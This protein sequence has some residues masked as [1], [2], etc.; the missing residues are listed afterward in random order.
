MKNTPGNPEIKAGQTSRGDKIDGDIVPYEKKYESR[1]EN[2]SKE[3]G[4]LE[5]NKRRKFLTVINN[6][7][8]RLLQELRIDHFITH[9]TGSVARNMCTEFSDIDL[10]LLIPESSQTINTIEFTANL[11]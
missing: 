6:Q 1:F 11:N 2:R 8:E 4:L 3:R 10:E 5:A 9:T 7:I